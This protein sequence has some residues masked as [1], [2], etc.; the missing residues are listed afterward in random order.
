MKRLW[1]GWR[2]WRKPL[3]WR[4]IWLSN[5]TVRAHQG[6]HT[7]HDSQYDSA[8]FISSRSQRHSTGGRLTPPDK[9]LVLAVDEKSQIQALD[10]AQPGLPMKK[11]RCGTMTHDYKR[12]GTTTLFAPVRGSLPP[13]H[14]RS[15]PAGRRLA[16]RL[17]V[18][19]RSAPAQLRWGACQGCSGPHCAPLLR[20]R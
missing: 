17:I 4:R 20:D 2:A 6:R 14:Q 10:R 7:H 1:E 13:S 16:T 3:T 9:A 19:P 18:G 5:P 15:G 12:N 11:G 8:V